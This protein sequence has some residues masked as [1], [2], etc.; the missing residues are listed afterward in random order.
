MAWWGAEQWDIQKLKSTIIISQD[1]ETKKKAVDALASY[2]RNALP[3]LTDLGFVL[4]DKD[5]R[6]YV[7]DKI[8]QINEATN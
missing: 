8:K 7:L 2:R 5:T 1:S 4:L 6:E 3:A